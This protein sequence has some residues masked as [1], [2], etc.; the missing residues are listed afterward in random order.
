VPIRT[1][2]VCKI[3]LRPTALG[4]VSVDECPSCKGVWFDDQEL[5]LAKDETDH[6]LIWMD[7]ELWKHPELFAADRRGLSCPSDGTALVDI[8][9]GE[10]P[11]RVAYCPSCRGVWLD[12]GE[13]A[14]IIKALEEQAVS[15]NVAQYVRASLAEA[16]ELFT[17]PESFLS[18]WRDLRAVLRLLRF[19]FLVEHGGLTSL[20][21]RIPRIG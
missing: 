21:E 13:F 3:A 11:V 9:Y 20:I 16:R 18:E 4:A 17:G 1:C 19:R 7:F 14:Q 6:D 15:M 12:K 5:R 2:P 10:T 8:R